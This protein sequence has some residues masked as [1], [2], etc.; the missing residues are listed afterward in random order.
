[1]FVQDPLCERRLHDIRPVK[2]IHAIGP[3]N[4]VL[5]FDWHLIRLAFMEVSCAHIS[6][7]LC[8]QSKPNRLPLP[9]QIL[10]KNVDE[11]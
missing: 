9:H 7:N 2:T 3:Y 11:Q 8:K 5:F 1:L 10:F 6:I 4:A